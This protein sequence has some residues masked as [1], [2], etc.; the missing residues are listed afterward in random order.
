MYCCR[1]AARSIY[2]VCCSLTAAAIAGSSFSTLRGAAAFHPSRLLLNKNV[3]RATASRLLV[4]R[5]VSTERSLFWRKPAISKG[6]Q[7]I[8]SSSST[9]VQKMSTDASMSSAS[10]STSTTADTQHI[11]ANLHHVQERV[12]AAAAA[13]ADGDETP[14]NHVRLVAVSKTKPLTLLQ[15]AYDA[16]CRCFG[17]NYVQ[18]L[19]EKAHAWSDRPDVQWHY[20]GALQSNKCKQLLQCCCSAASS[21]SNDNTA[22]RTTTTDVS[23][24][25]VETVPS[26]KLANKLNN[27]VQNLLDE[28][29]GE[30]TTDSQSPQQKQQ[31]LKVFVQVN[32]SGEESKSGVEAG[33]ECVE[34]C[35]YIVN[36]CPSLDLR[37]LMTIGAIGDVSCF[38]TLKH[39]RDEVLTAL[40]GRVSKLELSMGMSDDFEQAIQAGATNVRVGS[41]I[42]GARD[43]SQKA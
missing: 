40:D 33:S 31:Q 6:R 37:G 35:R 12:A 5:L 1:S 13:A 11:A 8:F 15:A 25:T 29:K 10:P 4:Q 7:T 16:G 3:H 38:A 32:T 19:V 36:E 23:R 27:A 18:E 20:I 9:S 26:I 21:G 34:L 41:T 28:A 2:C 17:E 42:F 30:T 43:Y 22:R 14:N 39:C 24:L